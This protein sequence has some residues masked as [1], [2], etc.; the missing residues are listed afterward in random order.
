MSITT[1]ATANAA[2][3]ARNTIDLGATSANQ[4]LSLAVDLANG[5]GAGQADLAWTDTRTL[6]AS[7]TEDLDLAGALANPF[8]VAQ[9]FARVKLLVIK[10]ADANTNNVQVTRPASNGFPLFLAASDGIAL[11]PGE[12]LMLA[13]GD[14]DA[15]GHVVTAATGDLLTITNSGGTTG[16]TY[17]IMVVGCSA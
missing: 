8:G 11:R 9:V 7:A 16:V 17:S 1:R 2:V 3:T 5:T 4:A 12:F 13:A 10:A 6:A 15:V 14:A